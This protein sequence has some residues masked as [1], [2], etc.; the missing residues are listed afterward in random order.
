MTAHRKTSCAIAKI[1]KLV[2]LIKI[3]SVKTTTAIK[4]NEQSNTLTEYI[5]KSETETSCSHITV[6]TH[7]QPFLHL[8]GLYNS[9]ETYPLLIN[10]T[11]NILFIL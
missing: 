7:S 6:N 10:P 1:N 3:K 5:K 8:I 4:T 2:T 11:Y 9:S